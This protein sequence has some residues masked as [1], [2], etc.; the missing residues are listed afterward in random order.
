M[1]SKSKVRGGPRGCGGGGPV[2]PDV[3]IPLRSTALGHPLNGC[4]AFY[5]LT[6]R[7]SAAARR[8]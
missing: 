3:A 2:S 7:C 6:R 5:R 4:S 1:K 8:A